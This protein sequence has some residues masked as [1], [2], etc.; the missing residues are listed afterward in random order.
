MFAIRPYMYLFS[1]MVLMSILWMLIFVG[2]FCFL[3]YKLLLLNRFWW[4]L[5]QKKKER[6]KI[7]DQM[8][9]TFFQFGRSCP[10]TARSSKSL[11]PTNWNMRNTSQLSEVSTNTWS[12]RYA[13]RFVL[14]YIIL[15]MC[16]FLFYMLK[17]NRNVKS[18]QICIGYLCLPNMGILNWNVEFFLGKLINC[19]KH[20]S[21]IKIKIPIARKKRIRYSL[22]IEREV[23]K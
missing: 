8:I 9:L 3:I 16:I 14:L 19:L 6:K 2:F 21:L 22:N 13:S 1:S 4:I 20:L 5:N 23:L 18:I 7:F 17:Q 15:M 11:A 10:D 12:A